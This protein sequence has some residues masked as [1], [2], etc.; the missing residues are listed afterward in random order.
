MLWQ[1]TFV[2]LLAHLAAATPLARRW[3][4]F[5]EK[6]SWPETPMDW[7]LYS[8]APKDHTFDL[9]IGLKPSGMEK[10]IEH[11]MEISD[12]THARYVKFVLPE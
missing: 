11:L 4:D 9:R 8:E 1:P 5:A 10:L 12:P 3:N 2:L 6:H 7:E